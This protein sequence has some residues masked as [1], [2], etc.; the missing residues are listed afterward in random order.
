MSVSAF[1]FILSVFSA[2][3]LGWGFIFLPRERWQ[4]LASVPV[5]RS[6]EGHWEGINLTFYGFLSANAYL[7]GVTAL[8]FLLGSLNVPLYPL[9]TLALCLLGVCIPA[10]SLIARWVEGKAHTFT[11]G[12]AVFIGIIAAPWIITGINS[13]TTGNHNVST[14]PL[15][16]CLAAMGIAYAFGEGFGRLACISFGCCYGKPVNTYPP[17]FRTL[18]SRIN[19]VFKG[20]TKKASYAGHLEGQP[21]VPV[22]AI[23]AVLYVITALAAM[24]LFLNAQFLAAFIL[25]GITTQGWR[26]VSETLRADY[27]GE[28][29]FSAYQWM[30]L[31]SVIY[32]TL[33]G[34]CAHFFNQAQA[35]P[36]PHIGNGLSIFWN[37]LLLL[38]L[39]MMWLLL[40]LYTGCSAVTGCNIS[41]YVKR[42]RI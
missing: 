39:Q 28:Q 17:L 1:I 41:F 16:P 20:A 38:A 27:R 26:V 34:I 9:L 21:L 14:L 24:A 13:V 30:G 42:E 31:I 2:A 7:L 19:L 32:I 33:T 29:K 3:Y 25:A 10:S 11:V 40:F 18:F 35:H 23:T 22:Q 36:L 4:M 8:I 6:D 37:P 15:L 12:G 5:H